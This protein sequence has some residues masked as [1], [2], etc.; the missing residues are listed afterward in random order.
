MER[1]GWSW[2]L[3]SMCRLLTD[4]QGRPRLVMGMA[5]PLHSKNHFAATVQRLIDENQFLRQHRVAFSSLTPR[6]RDVLR[7]L[8]LGVFSPRTS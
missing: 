8:A 2:Y 3:T 7:L 4:E 5:V 6:E 1:E